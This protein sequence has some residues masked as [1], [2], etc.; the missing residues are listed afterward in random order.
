LD[1]LFVN[2]AEELSIVESMGSGQLFLGSKQNCQ[3]ETAQSWT[4]RDRGASGETEA[5]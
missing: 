2:L 5:E 4:G 1:H 3:V